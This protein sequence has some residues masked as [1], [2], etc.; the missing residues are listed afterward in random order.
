MSADLAHNSDD[1]A[2]A[3]ASQFMISGIKHIPAIGQHIYI[4]AIQLRIELQVIL[5]VETR[6][7][8]GY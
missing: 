7:R 2:L 6:Q 4:P 1:D 5:L 8:L 3:L